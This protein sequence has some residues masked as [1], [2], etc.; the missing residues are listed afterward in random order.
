MEISTGDIVQVAGQ[1]MLLPWDGL[2][3]YNYFCREDIGI[4]TRVCDETDEICLLVGG[5]LLHAFFHQ[6]KKLIDS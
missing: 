1:Q 3:N 6:V 5:E 2:D 4:V